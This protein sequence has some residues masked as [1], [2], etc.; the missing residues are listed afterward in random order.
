MFSSPF[1]LLKRVSKWESEFSVEGRPPWWPGEPL[2]K[3]PSQEVVRPLVVS[4]C[5]SAQRPPRLSSALGLQRT[6][7][8]GNQPQSWGAVG[9]VPGRGRSLPGA[10][11][12]DGACGPLKDCACHPC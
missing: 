6:V 3:R 12:Q 8:D 1:K 11:L 5:A 2:D 7:L 4:S 10:G 9:A